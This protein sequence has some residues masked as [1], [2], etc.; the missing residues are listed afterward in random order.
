MY[1]WVT[2]IHSSD[3]MKKLCGAFRMVPKEGHMVDVSSLR[4]REDVIYVRILSQYIITWGR[5]SANI[6][7]HKLAQKVIVENKE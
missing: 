2:M 1:R 6:N 5:D 7:V 3:A 4:L